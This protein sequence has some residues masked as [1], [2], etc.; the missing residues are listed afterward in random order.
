MYEKVQSVEAKLQKIDGLWSCTECGLS[1]GCKTDVFNHVESKHLKSSYTCNY[2]GK[3]YASL[4]SLKS[5]VS[6][7][8]TNK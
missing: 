1:S 7:Y 4:N 5:H 2:C 6:R 3:V 8:H